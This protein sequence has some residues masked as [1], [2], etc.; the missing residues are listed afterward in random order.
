MKVS[1]T[2]NE[3]SD[4]GAVALEPSRVA[5]VRPVDDNT[6]AL[7]ANLKILHVLDHSLPLHSGYTFR[8]QSIFRTQRKRG[9]QAVVVTSPK[10]EESWK[11]PRNEHEEI[12][13]TSYYRT[14]DV[15]G[16]RVPLLAE[17]RLMAALER[18]LHEAIAVE[19]PDI[20]HAHSPIL[21]VLPA[22][23]AARATR[24]PVV[25]EIRAFWEDAAVDHGSYGAHS[26]KYALLR[27]A[28]TRACHRVAQVAVLCQGLRDDLIARGLPGDKL[29]IVANGID[30]DDFSPAVPD[31][32]LREKYHLAG[33]SIIGF[34]GSFYRYEGLDLLVEAFAR[35]A[36]RRSEI[37]LLLAGGGEVA[38]ELREQIKQL[39]IED[40]V[41][42]PGR[43]DHERI[44]GVYAL[45][46]VL[47]YPRRSMRLTELV[48]PLKPL[49]AMAMAKPLVA[50]NIG[51]HRELISD[52]RTGLL[53]RPGDTAALA[54]A[55]ASLLDDS[56][57]RRALGDRG[58]NW[59]RREHSWDKTTAIYSEIYARALRSSGR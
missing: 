8:S 4:R 32:Q 21:N 12:G 6:P 23:R 31:A 17:H 19:R 48:T 3:V 55:I 52:G 13:G 14:G 38:G 40:R 9:W 10:H 2:N 24:I 58:W 37:V 5:R 39:G 34:I 15:V 28:E 11:G 18:R 36:A 29:S 22:L 56:E 30:A 26:W 25:Y 42:M 45:M 33:K 20:I 35:L 7:P 54:A 27:A 16:G 49:E 1:S 51:G 59:V 47:A 46:D 43:I 53:F 41:V 44:P 57:L 50:S